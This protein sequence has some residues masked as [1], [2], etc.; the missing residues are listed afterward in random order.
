MPD[1]RITTQTDIQV[2][3]GGCNK[4]ICDHAIGGDDCITV[5]PCTNCLEK[6]RSRGYTEGHSDGYK[7]CEDDVNK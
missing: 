6:E 4:G 3:C 7:E 2:W 5:E 1:V